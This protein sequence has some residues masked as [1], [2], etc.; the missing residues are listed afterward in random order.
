[1]I[2]KTI[3]TIN[4]SL[5]L[6]GISTL[7]LLKSPTAFADMPIP[8]SSPYLS[9]CRSFSSS[10]CADYII[11]DKLFLTIFYFLAGTLL[12]EIPIF[13]LFG[14]RTKKKLGLAI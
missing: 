12:I 2:K 3:S 13:V 5:F 8:S 1:M 7:S 4:R 6:L 14:F 11:W 9:Q 10:T